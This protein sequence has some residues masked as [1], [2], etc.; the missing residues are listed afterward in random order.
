MRASTSSTP[1]CCGAVL[2]AASANA[3][4]VAQADAQAKRAARAARS[5]ALRHRPDRRQRLG[6]A[7]ASRG[8]PDAGGR[9]VRW[10]TGTRMESF[11]LLV[12][13]VGLLA[14]PIVGAAMCAAVVAEPKSPRLFRGDCVTISYRQFSD[15]EGGTERGWLSA[16]LSVPRAAAF[17]A[18]SLRTCDGTIA[19]DVRSDDPAFNAEV[20]IRSS[21]PDGVARLL[22]D[23]ELRS[24]LLSVL[25]A[26]EQRGD[27]TTQAQRFTVTRIR[28]SA[29][30]ELEVE[31]DGLLPEREEDPLV[32][33]VLELASHLIRV[34]SGR[35]A[36]ATSTSAI[37]WTA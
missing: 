24:C 22:R 2:A 1:E 20:C 26:G 31:M 19:T 28:L 21:Q 32:R 34:T 36:P 9:V 5:D 7:R 23:A 10:T 18:I 35:G 4:V 30:G 3:D 33:P 12:G 11:F 29:D 15:P 16:S 27:S 13:F 14:S 8:V 37:A 6:T 25:H 17:S